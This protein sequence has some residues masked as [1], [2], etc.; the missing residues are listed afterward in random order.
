MQQSMVSVIL[1]ASD[2]EKKH[3]LFLTISSLSLSGCGFPIDQE[4][5]KTRLDEIENHEVN[6]DN[7]NAV[8]I[9]KKSEII[10]ESKR[11]NII[12]KTTTNV[13][14]DGSINTKKYLNFLKIIISRARNN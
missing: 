4:S 12:S 1:K 8:T 11:N 9:S 7:I 14:A 2:M 13:E 5:A 3:L 10:L 6:I